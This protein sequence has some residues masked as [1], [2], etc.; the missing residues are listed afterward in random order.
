MNASSSHEDAADG[1]L[2]QQRT[3]S[4]A[5]TSHQRAAGISGCGFTGANR[6]VVLIAHFQAWTF[7]HPALS[8]PPEPLARTVGLV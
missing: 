5:W 7:A 3:R 1:H 4:P 2:T 8:D 6:E